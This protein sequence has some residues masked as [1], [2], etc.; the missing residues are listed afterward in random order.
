MALVTTFVSG[1]LYAPDGSPLANTPV[2]IRLTKQDRDMDIVVPEIVNATTNANGLLALPLWPNERG[3]AGS[4]YRVTVKN[5]GGAGDRRVFDRLMT[6]PDTG[7]AAL[8]EILDS[9]PPDTQSVS[10]ALAAATRAEAAADAAA[11]SASD[12]LQS[13]FVSGEYADDAG[14]SATAAAAS[15]AEA[16]GYRSQ[17]QTLRDQTE[18]LRDQANA[19]VTSTSASAS[20]AAAS[21]AASQNSAV[22]AGNQAFMSGQSATAAA[23][24][25]SQSSASAASAAASAASAMSS[26]MQAAT[27][28]SNSEAS[29]VESAASAAEALLTLSATEEVY[30]DVLSSLV[31]SGRYSPTYQD[32]LNAIAQYQEGEVLLVLSDETYGGRRTY[33]R[34]QAGAMTNAS[35]V[36]DFTAG[37]DA[38]GVLTTPSMAADFITDSYSL[39]ESAGAGDTLGAFASGYPYEFVTADQINIVAVPP[40]ATSPAILGDFAVNSTHLYVA[41]GPDAWKR[42][43][44]E[45]F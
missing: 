9:D 26:A 7:T 8:A 22:E 24:S 41:T 34:V 3:S 15:A 39:F 11:T 16:L 17:T 1:Y 32:A 20:A 36:V 6:V 40:T 31:T 4:Q 30:Q 38:L 23:A 45:A 5:F 35:L 33:Y 44:L 29:A 10:S 19:T 27:S 28:A 13:S 14:V 12:A 18:V 43:T 2:T 21:A 42:I 25:A 37:A